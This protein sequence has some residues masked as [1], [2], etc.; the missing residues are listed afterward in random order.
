[1]SDLGLH[2][3]EL[4]PEKTYQGDVDAESRQAN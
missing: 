4:S 1:M 2:A 3:L